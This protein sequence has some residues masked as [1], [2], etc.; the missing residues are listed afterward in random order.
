MA[1]IIKLIPLMMMPTTSSMSEAIWQPSGRI[2]H[3]KRYVT[4]G[5]INV[6]KHFECH[7]PISSIHYDREKHIHSFT[8][9]V[10]FYRHVDPTCLQKALCR[11]F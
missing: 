7:L 9:H 2:T 3:R 1:H 4:S 11:F 8:Q 10:Y 5:Q 6:M